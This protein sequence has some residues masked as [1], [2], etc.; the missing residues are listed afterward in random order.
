MAENNKIKISELAQATSFSGVE[1]IPM[2]VE[3]GNRSATLSVLKEYFKDSSL[4]IFYDIDHTENVDITDEPLDASSE[5]YA[6]IDVVFVSSKNIF[7]ERYMDSSGRRYFST[8]FTRWQD[9][10]EV[11]ANTGTKEVRRDK[12]FFNLSD[13][14]LY[15]F[16]GSLQSI[17]NSIRI[18]AMT[19]EEFSKLEN[20]IEGAFYA[21]YE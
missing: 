13:K 11:N 8:T 12:V 16:N 10:L 3:G 14:E 2:A 21:T 18:N 5:T 9:F 1:R 20:P 17:F 19:E 15:T 4:C 7:A 6:F